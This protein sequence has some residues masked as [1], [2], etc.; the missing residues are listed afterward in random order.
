[1]HK[2]LSSRHAMDY[3]GKELATKSFRLQLYAKQFR[4]CTG[5]NPCTVLF[6]DFTSTYH[7]ETNI[8]ARSC[9]H[10]CMMRSQMDTLLTK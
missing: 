9:R 5:L 10:P 4:N 3:R 8:V 2:S 7:D 1:M 6:G